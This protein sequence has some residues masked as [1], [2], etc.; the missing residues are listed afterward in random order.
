MFQGVAGARRARSAQT[1]NTATLAASMTMNDV[2]ARLSARLKSPSPGVSAK[3]SA[4]PN[5]A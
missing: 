1:T 3:Y 2:C 4:S 5:I